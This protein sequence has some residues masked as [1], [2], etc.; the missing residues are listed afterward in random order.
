MQRVSEGR[1]VSVGIPRG[2]TYS[3]S[4][5]MRLGP[6]TGPERNLFFVVVDDESVALGLV[7]Q[8]QSAKDSTGGD[9]WAVKAAPGGHR[10]M[11]EVGG[12]TS[13]TRSPSHTASSHVRLQRPPR[14]GRAAP[15]V[16]CRRRRSDVP[17]SRQFARQQ[18]PPHDHVPQETVRGVDERGGAVLLIIEVPHP[19]KAIAADERSHGWIPLSREHLTEQAWRTRAGGWGEAKGPRYRGR[20]PGL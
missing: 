3:A 5:S 2:L 10:L 7:S 17:Q 4:V 13:N 1:Q 8:C 12:S 9:R 15:L 6:A 20:L 11:V 16:P 18:L 14:P 19:R